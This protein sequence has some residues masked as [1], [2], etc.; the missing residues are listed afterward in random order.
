MPETNFFWDPLSDNILQERDETGA[1]TAEYTTEPGLYGNLIS[2]NR[3]GVE[4]QYH[5]DAQ[6]ST[7]A[8]TDDAQQLTDTSAYTAFGKLSEQTGSTIYPYLYIARQG[9]YTLAV[10]DE[11]SVRRR[12]FSNG[13]WLSPDPLYLATTESQYTY[14]RNRPTYAFDPSGLAGIVYVPP[15]DSHPWKEDKIGGGYLGGTDCSWRNLTC[16]CIV[17]TIRCLADNRCVV[18]AT[19]DVELMTWIRLDIDLIKSDPQYGHGITIV[20]TYGHEQQHVQCFY[21]LA[22]KAINNRSGVVN[23]VYSTKGRCYIPADC[24]AKAAK[25]QAG[26][27]T[28]LNDIVAKEKMHGNPCSPVPNTDCPPIGTMPKEPGD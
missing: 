24:A 1:V 27:V 7:L 23:Y 19:C 18:K 9:Y 12:T 13:R 26:I 11:Y 25:A 28:D 5:F 8:L 4:S 6:G 15:V 17:E 22:T 16:Y 20:G 21:N 14:S 10:L 3:G 2:Q